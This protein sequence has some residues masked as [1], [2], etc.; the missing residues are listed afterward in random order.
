MML[1]LRRARGWLLRAVLKRTTAIALGTLFCAP[2]LW[3][4]WRD[5]R[6]ETWFTDGLA[7]VAGAT[8]I[9]FILAGIGGR[10][11]D[12]IAPER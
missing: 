10:K 11:P 12:W 1:N 5:Y 3:L 4:W 6:W 8:G 2:A 9:A 7:L